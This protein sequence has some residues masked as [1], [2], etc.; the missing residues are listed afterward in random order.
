MNKKIALS[1]IIFIHFNAHAQIAGKGVFA[2]LNMQPSARSLALGTNFIS[3][4]DNDLSVGYQN[5]AAM[6][7]KMHNY[8]FASYNNYVSDI[9]TG[10]FGYARH[11]K[12]VGTFS[13]NVFYFDYGKF[14]GYLPNG[15]PTGTFTV[16]D[17]TFQI[18][19]G[20]NYKEKFRYGASLK[21][22]YS[23]YEQYVSNGI[24]SDLSAIYTDTANKMDISLIARNIG[25]QAIPY[26]GTER[27]PLAFEMALAFSKKLKYLPFKYNIVLNNLQQPDMRYD[28]KNTNQRDEQGNERVKKMTMGDNLLRHLVVGGEFNLSKHFI[29]R[30]GYN[31][32]RRKEAAPEQKKGTTG[33]SWGLGFKISKFNI[34]YG[35]ASLFPGFN[36]N[37]FSLLCNLG[38]FYK[39]K[40]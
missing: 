5:P 36:T 29:V 22:I 13:A 38:N 33:F 2:F 25:F 17:Q 26:R 34:S 32:Q 7:A 16:K 11:Y 39:K 10:F 6:N 35:S 1:L 8:A 40:G 12:N 30:F 20:N 27:Q 3:S 37:Q 24:A 18:N 31:H 23:I 19:Y 4:I 14:D 15:L 9:N 28:I 21:Y